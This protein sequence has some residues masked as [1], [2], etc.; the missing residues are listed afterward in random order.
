[1]HLRT[2]K[3]K[4]DILPLYQISP[5]CIPGRKRKFQKKERS[6][7]G[8]MLKTEKMGKIQA[9]RKF[10]RKKE[11]ISADFGDFQEYFPHFREKSFE[12][13]PARHVSEI[14]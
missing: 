5:F 4:P 10:D 3:T 2:K 6:T 14:P 8:R 13:V 7:G 11:W 1:M 9:G 12:K